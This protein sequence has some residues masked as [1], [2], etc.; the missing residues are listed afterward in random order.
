MIVAPG[1]LGAQLRI[2]LTPGINRQRLLQR[3]QHYIQIAGQAD[4]RLTELVQFSRID[5][6]MDNF[7][8][9]GKR[10]QLAGDAIVKAGAYRDQ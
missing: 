10:I 7:G 1:V 3:G 4:M 9:R 8:V 6:H 5:I 2:T